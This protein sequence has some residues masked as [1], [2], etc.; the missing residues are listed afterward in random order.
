[1]AGWTAGPT[2]VDLIVARLTTGG[3][4]DPSFAGT[5]TVVVNLGG[6]EWGNAVAIAP[7]G[8]IVVAGTLRLGA[9]QDFLLVRL[10]PDGSFDGSFGNGGRSVLNPVGRVDDGRSVVVQPDGKIA[11]V[12]TVFLSATAGF[13]E[14][15]RVTAAGAWDP[16]F[17]EDGHTRLQL[18][19]QRRGPRAGDRS[20]T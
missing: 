6:N 5:G 9:E 1:M 16:T 3:D 8:K 7:D 10:N 11:F 19:R 15:E 17:H 20:A 14:V 18:R 12:G 4:L 2:G 13:A